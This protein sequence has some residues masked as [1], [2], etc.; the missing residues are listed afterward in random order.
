MIDDIFTVAKRWRRSGVVRVTR[1]ASR[2][3]TGAWTFATG[4]GGNSNTYHQDYVV[5]ATPT[6]IALMDE[7]A[8]WIT[9]ES[10]GETL[11]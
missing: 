9:N 6:A 7:D 8:K 4:G 2:K 10:H 3:R 5:M 1:S 11:N